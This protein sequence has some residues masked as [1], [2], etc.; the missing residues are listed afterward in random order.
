[1]YSIIMKMV[2]T[3]VKIVGFQRWLF[4]IRHERFDFNKKY[5]PIKKQELL[6][7]L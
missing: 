1:M 5:F 3:N 2:L 7:T 4:T 6:K